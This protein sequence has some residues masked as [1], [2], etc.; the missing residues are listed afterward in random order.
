[1]YDYSYFLRQLPQEVIDGATVVPSLITASTLASEGYLYQGIYFYKYT[2][3]GLDITISGDI[4]LGT[5]KVAL[6]TKG[7]D[8]YLNGKI[9]L[10]D[11]AGF[12][13]LFAGKDDLGVKGNIYISP[14]VSGVTPS[15]EGIYLA[16]GTIY[17]GTNGVDL[18]SR[19]I[20]RGSL[21]GIT[22]ISLQRDLV[23]DS[24]T[25]AELFEYAPDQIM[26]LLN[27]SALSAK[28]MS[29]KEVAP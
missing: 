12:F 4:N 18:D 11:G 14:T 17:T 2:S 6:L 3:E 10:T 13:A 8:I 23:D 22:G 27:S 19:L 28:K 15:L 20:T 9:N 25:P 29:W 24:S 16:D 7:A 21:A 26:I 1:V 5:R